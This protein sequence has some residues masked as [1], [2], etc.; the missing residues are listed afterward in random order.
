LDV[1]SQPFTNPSLLLTY[2]YLPR[3]LF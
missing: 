1:S 2:N 3:P